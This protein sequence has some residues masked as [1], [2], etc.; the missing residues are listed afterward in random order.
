M[1]KVSV[2]IAAYNVENTIANALES[3]IAQTLDDI[4]I[5]VIDDCSTDNTS[6]ILAEYEKKDARIKIIKHDSNK[7]LMQVRKTGVK[8]ATGEY[9][10]F[11]DGDDSLVSDACEKAYHAIDKASSDVLQFDANIV[12]EAQKEENK[13]IEGALNESLKPID[14][15]IQ[16]SGKG[17]LLAAKETIVF[18]IWNKIYKRT[19]C[20]E[21]VAQIPNEYVNMSEDVMFGYL[22]QYYASS[23]ASIKNHLYNY[24]YGN[25]MST[26]NELSQK[27]LEATAKNAYVFQ[28]LKEWTQ[29]QG[30]AAECQSGL[31]Q[32]FQQVFY[33][34]CDTF[35]KKA[36][37]NQ[38]NSLIEAVNA[39]CDVEDIVIAFSNYMHDQRVAKE[40]CSVELSKLDL[41][42]H[43]KKEIK[44]VGVFYFR[45]FNGGIENV[46][47]SLSTIWVD[48]GYEMV[49]FTDKEPNE[50]DYPLHPAVKRVV[51]P[52]MTDEK[53]ETQKKRIQAFRKALI[54]NH[55]DVMV[56]NAWTNPHL[57]LDQMIV[58]SC[59]ISLIIHTHNLFCCETDN[60]NPWISYRY[61]SLNQT[62]ALADSIVTLTD[63]DTAWWQALGIRTFK[64]VNPIQLPLSTEPSKLNGNSVLLVAR[65]GWE[66]NIIDAL[67]IIQKVHQVIPDATLTVL[68]KG[69][70]PTYVR[71]VYKY[72]ED[73][74]MKDYVNMAGFDTNVLPYYQKADILLSTAKFEG[75]GLALLESKICG[76][77]MV[78]YELPNLDITKDGRGMR[79]IEQGN[80]DAAADAIIEIL[81]NDELKKQLGQKARESAQDYCSID[82]GKHWETIFNKTLLPKEPPIPLSQRTPLEAAICIAVEHYSTGLYKHVTTRAPQVYDNSAATE[83]L[84]QLSRISRSESY[85][86]GLVLTYIPRKLKQLLKKIL[87]R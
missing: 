9:I 53:P 84:H 26:A 48:H 28:Y 74:E 18:T 13:E 29:K 80:V 68:G 56:Y 59:G 64:T 2:I 86:L 16:V 67:K 76:M 51:L 72:I 81:R 85:R 21:V 39:Y 75:F 49:L 47:S 30:T 12:F 55:V 19:L 78:C 41:F 73:H 43:K 50:N 31:D 1:S 71:S 52:E 42:A 3:V 83:A 34:I 60:E 58:K 65:I 25:G 15:P 32:V 69:D 5:I 24:S 36:A 11:L 87:R 10:M 63:V 82:L 54:D 46:I 23:Y 77:P 66:K 57:V 14:T 70:D 7:S 35:F 17:G 61:S 20:Q 22:A 6:Q 38:R 4:E 79:V 33:Y 37:K 45:L 62:Y 27:Q 8:V 40:L 44:T